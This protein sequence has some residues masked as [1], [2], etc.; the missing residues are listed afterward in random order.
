M[1]IQF[2]PKLR[3]LNPSGSENIGTIESWIS[4]VMYNL[5][6]NPVFKPYLKPGAKFGTKTNAKPTR[7]LTDD[8]GEGALTKE[9]KCIHVDLMLDQIANWVADVLPRHNITRDCGSLDD[10]WEMIKRNYDLETTGSLLNHAWNVTRKPDETPQALFSRLKQTY[11]QNLLRKDGLMHVNGRLAADEEMS[12]TLLNTVI[13]HWLQILHPR[14]RDLVTQ[15][16]A[17]ELRDRTY[18]AIYPE[19]SRSITELLHECTEGSSVMRAYS[20]GYGR[21]GRS[22]GAR[23]RASGYGGSRGRSSD[24]GRGY[25][26]SR[27]YSSGF[28][29]VSRPKGCDYCKVAGR[30]CFRNHDMSDCIFLSQENNVRACDEYDDYDDSYHGDYGDVPAYGE[31]CHEVVPAAFKRITEHV[32]NRIS[33]VASPVLPLFHEGDCISCVLDSGATCNCIKSDIVRRAGLPIYPTNQTVKLGD[34]M[35]QLKVEGETEIVF[36]RGDR[37]FRMVAL[38]V[39][40]ADT[41]VLCGMPFLVENDVAIRPAKNQIIIHGEEIVQYNPTTTQAKPVRRMVSYDIVSPTRQVILPGQ[42]WSVPVP[43]YVHKDQPLAI[44]PRFDTYHNTKVKESSI[45]PPPQVVD[46]VDGV[47]SLIN[48]TDRPVVLK[49]T[50]KVFK[51]FNTYEPDTLTDSYRGVDSDISDKPIR[52]TPP[53]DM[54]KVAPHSSSVQLNPDKILTPSTEVLFKETLLEYDNVFSPK[55]TGYNG[56]SGPCMVEVNMGATKPPQRKGRI[57]MYSRGNLEELQRK[58]DELEEKGVF[59][60]PQSIGVQVEYVVPSFLVAKRN[61]GFR[62]V[63]DFKSIAPYIKPTPTLLPDVNSTLLKIGSWKFLIKADFI[64]AYFQLLLKRKS[65]RYCGVATPFK[66]LR[67]YATGCMG[68]PGTETALE[69]LTCLVLGDLVMR[70]IVAKVA[71]DLFI[72]GATEAEL[73]DNFR[74]VLQ[75]LHEN[76]LKLS[77]RKTI[78]APVSTEILGW[79]WCGGKLQASAHR[80]SALAAC[81]KP[82]TVS[83]MRSYLGMYKYL[84]RVLKDHAVLL[85]PLEA[86]IAGKE[87]NVKIVWSDELVEAFVRS[88]EA[89]KDN[90]AITIPVPSDT[91]WIVTDGSLRNKAVGATLYLVRDGATKLGGFFSGRVNKCQAGWLA[92]E[93]EGVAIATALHHFAPLIRQSVHTP[94]VLTDSKPC[95]Q[96]CEKFAR[97]E[98]S[99]SARLCTFLNAVGVYRAEVSHISGKFNITSDFASRNPVE[100]TNPRCEICKF[101]DDLVDS[102]VAAV[103]LAD[104]EAG[105]VRMPFT[106]PTA[107]L[108]T[109]SECKDLRQVK[110]YLDLGSSPPRKMKGAKDIRRYLSA[111]VLINSKGLL[112]VREAEPLKAVH[113]RV[114]VPRPV[115]VGF[116][117]SLHIQCGH[118]TAY[119]M[120][121]VFSRYFFALDIDKYMDETTAACYQCA[122]IRDIP[123]SLVKQSSESP[124]DHV[125]SRFAADVVKRHGQNIF[126]LRETVT[127]YTEAELVPDETVASI[128]GVILRTIS[129]LRPSEASPAVIRVDPAPAHQS[130]FAEGEELQR[131]NI[132]LEIGR[133]KNVNKNPVIDKAVKEMIREIQV[134][135]L[136]GPLSSTTLGLVIASLNSRLRASGLSAHELWTQRDQVSHTQ[137]PICDR[138]I[139]KRQNQ[140]RRDNHKYSERSKAHGRDSLPMADISVGDLVYIHSDGNKLGPR[141]RYMVVSIDGTWCTVR[142]MDGTLFAS[143]TYDLRLDEVYKVP[144]FDFGTIHEDSDSDSDMV[145]VSWDIDRQPRRPEPILPVHAPGPILPV[146]MPDP[147]IQPAPVPIV[148]AQGGPVDVIPA[149]EDPIRV[150]LPRILQPPPGSPV[151]GPPTGRHGLRNRNHMKPPER[152]AD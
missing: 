108:E 140:T 136:K 76:G 23:G 60:K 120:K 22:G 126:I 8:T 127:S 39:P 59:V 43:S 123:K 54:K 93:I 57:P 109:Q 12:P 70:G 41:D 84:C 147:V 46:P 3:Q 52:P 36:H 31:G 40:F 35:T 65:M 17:M 75:R 47:V 124:P 80:I 114:V 34:G 77:A 24:Y 96:A 37:S 94:R 42:S 118:P 111:K 106:N 78:I 32:L 125:A 64:D 90:R 142:K 150:D 66:G 28:G 146:H 10:I 1:S 119:Q 48:E 122:A 95:V 58:F 92:C 117:T 98:F 113:D 63:S 11:D 128:N 50:E 138:D 100:C 137:L 143:R 81:P 131:H 68:L 67:V 105:K 86:V 130:L 115:I 87:K 55:F 30:R 13:L 74:L 56:H 145:P 72:G 134:K 4:Q 69:E 73:L 82:E 103:T 14:L 139:I 9:E 33:S 27:G 129:R 53:V 38:V 112:V 121:K 110:F 116:L 61:G 149:H 16:F 21:D 18:A 20:G 101:V 151:T 97:G 62:L 133:F 29:S 7:D 79:T 44:E 5:T 25:G 71:D 152:L 15:R 144:G 2:G 102:V 45:W 49:K 89:L 51:V 99:T 135:A 85:E 104:I 132:K 148:P 6:L 141:P 91:L 19:I 83:A 26:Q 107:W 88:Q